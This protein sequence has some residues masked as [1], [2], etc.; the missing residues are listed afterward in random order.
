MLR[1]LHAG[2][3]HL[4][5]PL[6]QFAPR[7]AARRRERQFIALEGLFADAVDRGAQM[8]LLAGDVFDSPTPDE[9]GAARFL[10]ILK[11]QPVP[12]LISPG[13][14]DYLR[15][16]GVWQRHALPDNVY[17]FDSPKLSCIDFPTLGTAVY[18]YAFTAE[19]A[20]APTLG[21]ASDL[22]P[23]RIS[24]L[25]AHGDLLSPLSP[26]APIGGGQLE[27]SGFAYA[28]LGHIHNPTPPRQYGRTLAAYSG[29]FAGR[30]F[31]EVGAGQALLVEI[32]GEHVGTTV[33]ASTADTFQVRELDCTGAQN[34]EEVRARVRDFLLSEAIGNETALRLCL[35]GH[36]GLSCRPD[37]VA[38]GALGEGFALFEVRD[39]TVPIFDGAYLAKDPTLRGAFYR[40]L[41]PQLTDGDEETRS[42]AAE[43]L[44]LGFAALSGR[45]V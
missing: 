26:Y 40:A 5:S 3:L 23:D 27:L 21:L 42:L 22:L 43:A 7:T 39:M 37:P 9:D 6:A 4:C 28:A 19:T 8:I 18:G 29:F 45:E 36:V 25:L 35:T 11:E 34:G 38:L 20:Q 10:S 12:V 15:E 31:D 1:F 30:G 41:L 13:N 17:L 16:G 24:I 14:H 44:R 33:L 2:D 32:E